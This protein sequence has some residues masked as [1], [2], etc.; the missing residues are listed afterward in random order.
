MNLDDMRA[1]V[2]DD[3]QLSLDLIGGMALR[4]GLKAALFLNPLEALDYIR[5]N[6]VDL[7]FTDF[8][9][10]GMDGVAL[11]REI[12]RIHSDIPIVMITAVDDD[13]SLRIRALE[14]GAT[15]FLTK[16]FNAPEFT[17]RAMNLA[18]L[19]SFQV[20]QKARG[21]LLERE[22]AKATGEIVKREHETLLVLGKAA[23][24]RDHETGNHT[25]RMGHYARVLARGMGLAEGIQN[26]IFHAAP[27]HDVGKIGISDSIL[28]KPGKLTCAEFEILKTHTTIGY[29][30][31]RGSSSPYLEAASVIAATHHEKYDG[32]GYPSGLAGEAIPVEGRISAVADVFDV[33][34]SKRPYKEPWS[35]DDA[36]RLV[37]ECKGSHFDPKVVG[38]LIEQQEEIQAVYSHFSDAGFQGL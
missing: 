13:V 34:T 38:T 7:V 31:L 26:M 10:P 1:V 15:D 36:V 21:D 35:L 18:S 12:R 2:I 3:S 11:T 6:P 29:N 23:E 9:M 14:S 33:L 24:F 27:L 8:V 5:K 22:V 20:M 32:T 4:I 37:Q 25:V 19:R 28:L 17:A 30:I 16:P